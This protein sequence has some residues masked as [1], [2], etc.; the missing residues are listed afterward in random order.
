MRGILILWGI[1]KVS[2]DTAGALTGTWA[3]NSSAGYAT[4][5][6]AIAALPD[7]PTGELCIGYVTVQA[8]SDGTWLAGTD[9]LQGGT[10]GDVSQD[11]NYY[12]ILDPNVEPADP[13]TES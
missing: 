8:K 13:D 3:T 6:L 7:T 2:V 5:A 10:G 4:E 9:A 11:T 12:N 1:M